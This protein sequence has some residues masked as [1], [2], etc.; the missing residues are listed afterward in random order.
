[1]KK[2]GYAAMTFT[3]VLFL[4]GAYL[5][6]YFTRRK[7]GMARY[8][9]YKNQSWEQDFPMETLKYT[10]VAVL[11]AVTLLLLAIWI[12]RRKGQEKPAPFTY[13]A[14][15]ILTTLYVSYTCISSIKTMRAYYFI[16]LLLGLAA[17]LQIVKAGAALIMGGKK[18]DE[19]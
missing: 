5:V 1:M 19:R 4:A 14:M 16:S 8:V 9:I 11:T 13:A 15:T 10:A 18:K 17:L 12:K 2:I 7:M 3:E 6:H